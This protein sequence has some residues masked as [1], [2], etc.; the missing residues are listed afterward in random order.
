M[1]ARLAICIMLIKTLLR[2]RRLKEQDNGSNFFSSE[3]LHN[4]LGMRMLM[5]L[6]MKCLIF[7]F[8]QILI[9]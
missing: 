9:L 4:Q 8:L 5:G 3:E 1:K 7:V 6:I 2:T